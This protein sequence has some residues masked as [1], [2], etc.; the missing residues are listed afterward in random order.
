MI[1]NDVEIANHKFQYPSHHTRHRPKSFYIIFKYLTQ[2]VC[3]AIYI[4][5][6][7]PCLYWHYFSINLWFALS[8]KHKQGAILP[9]W[10]MWC[11][12]FIIIIKQHG[13]GHNS[14]I[15]ADLFCICQKVL[16]ISFIFLVLFIFRT[17]KT[18]KNCGEMSLFTWVTIFPCQSRS[19]IHA[20][21]T[22]TQNAAMS[23]IIR[24]RAIKI[25]LDCMSARA[26]NIP[27]ASL[28]NHLKSS[29]RARHAEGSELRIWKK[30]N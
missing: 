2:S 16:I 19:I 1:N 30:K 4:R 18:H 8:I 20:T 17:K 15:G 23:G 27:S 25:S 12:G 5:Y 24:E 28:I 13:V 26:R 7:F 29:G 6:I 3:N 22:R 14:Y 11:F 9:G 10:M 21:P